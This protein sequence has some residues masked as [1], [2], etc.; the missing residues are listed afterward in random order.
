[1]FARLRV[2]MVVF[3]VGAAVCCGSNSSSSP[4][5]S[6]TPTPLSG[7]W[8]GTETDTVAGTGN[9]QATIFQSGSTLS[10]TYSLSFPNPIFS[11]SGSVSGT[12]NGS[13]VSMTATPTNPAIC[14]ALDTATLNATSTQITGT[15]VAINGCN[16]SHQTGSFTATKQ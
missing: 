5:S 12:V 14:P 10:G 11:N 9:L 15:Y 2:L 7:N 3:S 13:S 1:M 6:S 8:V 16:L 4:T